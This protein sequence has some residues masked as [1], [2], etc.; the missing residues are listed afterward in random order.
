V[1][2]TVGDFETKAPPA[3]PSGADGSVNWQ[4][5]LLVAE[6]FRIIRFVG[7]GGMGKVY[8]AQDETLGRS[9]ALK[10][11]PQEIIF[12]GDARDDLR[13][14]ANRLLDLAH[15]NIVRIHTYY[16]GPTWP[17]FAMEYLQ[18]PTL[19][20][21][22]RMRKQYGRTFGAGEVLAVARQVARGLS[23]AHAKGIIHRDLKPGNLMIAEPPG[24]R[25]ADADVIKI[26]DFGVSRV[27]A[28]STMRQTGKR[29][30]TLPYMSP[31]QFRGEP[32]TVQSDVYSFACTLYE[33]LSGK[34]PFY[35]GDIG[36]QIMNVSPKPLAGVAKPVRDALVRGLS[37]DPRQRFQSVSE[38]MNALEG[39]GKV[40]KPEGTRRTLS[41]SEKTAVALLAALLLLVFIFIGEQLVEKARDVS[42][43]ADTS[44]GQQ[45]YRN[46]PGAGRSEPG[47]VQVG[48][49][50]TGSRR[51][52]R[53]EFSS[54]L[55]DQ[56]QRQ[57][58]PLVG[59]D[60]A[61]PS[62]GSSDNI[63]LQV[64]VPESSRSSYQRS[65]LDGLL[66]EYYQKDPPGAALSS[67]HAP[68]GATMNVARV[69]G[70]SVQPG[71]SGAA[72]SS[73]LFQ[74]GNLREGA[75]T[76]KAYVEGVG[77]SPEPL[78]EDD[79]ISFRVD[80]TP[81]IFEV[82]PLHPGVF[83]ESLPTYRSTFDEV[84][85]LQLVSTNG[86]DDIAEAFSQIVFKQQA[87]PYE[88]IDSPRSWRIELPPGW[89][90][91]KVFAK[92]A[93]ANRSA[94]REV[95]F[96]RLRLGVESFEL[97]SPEGVSGNLATVK[98]VL[99]VEGDQ[100]PSL[101][102]FVNDRLVQPEPGGTRPLR[103][104]PEEDA[105]ILKGPD[106]LPF[107]GILRLPDL[108]N[109]I[110]V[111]YAWKENPPQPFA[112]PMRIVDVKVRA[113][114]VSLSPIQGRTSQ[115]RAKI[116]GRVEPYFE[117][118]EVALQRPGQGVLKLDLAKTSGGLPMATFA[119]EID[120]IPNENTFRVQCFYDGHLLEPSPPDVSIYYDKERPSL[121]EPLR[122]EVMGE[123]LYVTIR[124]A[125]EL[126]QLR[127][128][129][130]AV[131]EFSG[132]GHRAE[133]RIV[134]PD[135]LS[136]VYK[137]VTMLPSPPS[138]PIT[139]RIE[140]TDLAGNVEYK[141]QPFSLALFSGG[142]LASTAFSERS[143]GR[144]VDTA[145]SRI[146][147]KESGPAARV[148][149]SQ[150]VTLITSRFL[151]EMEMEFV[152]VGQD[153]L[154]MGRAE[155]PERAWFRFLREKSYGETRQGSTNY[156]MTLGDFSPSLLREFV[157]WF[158]E[159]SSDGYAY[160]I[161]TQEQWMAAFCAAGDPVEARDKIKE[162][163]FGTRKDQQRFEP[164]PEVRYGVN[165]VYP[166]GSRKEN[167]TPAGLL[168]ME[169]NVQEVVLDGDAFKVI[170]GSNQENE[171]EILQRTL[172][173]RPFGE[174]ERGPQGR[175]TGFR[176]CR[177]PAIS[178]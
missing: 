145:G 117:G 53:L 127:I 115:V 106:A 76:L 105:G 109:T 88:K 126:R 30:G 36:Y 89:S 50:E 167:R 107:A 149:G 143:S 174:L 35:T 168:D 84:V 114:R 144:A 98:G 171:Q 132:L 141:D 83:V 175:M 135:S 82:E 64:F 140:M 147:D 154:E 42:R 21:L 133:W 121:R 79:P 108:T 99:R 173:A 75:Y 73:R 12:D 29:S 20:K 65:L 71:L 151:E 9:I 49:V 18:G 74:L 162:W 33:L 122:F 102:Y 77:P 34:P 87:L 58:P 119:R 63:S 170:G 120:L 136:L 68:E 45:G 61:S 43:G 139:F 31:E 116:E 130:V 69:R 129:E 166:I 153:R 54:F 10:R 125:E 112:R 67:S 52:E 103:G 40:A 86:I 23:Y 27:V 38:L 142:S 2:V 15:E 55:R 148:T 158:E 172:E 137:Y 160:F 164:H 123:L 4:E 104:E 90:T 19:K 62:P 161:P 14:E 6:R 81:P 152:P 44:G 78:M 39:K 146:E 159:K 131:T 128:Q 59:R 41:L 46:P 51:E 80:L 48:R 25:I 47:T 96:R 178:R 57:I 118:L 150:G 157:K 177:K 26:T 1:D 16:D 100:S 32:C 101:R 156:P 155:V 169:S 17:F 70:T 93:A 66:L 37:K 13:Q 165:K 111:R 28:D 3:A 92:D 176:L 24:E 124:P 5:G 97:A 7:Q 22:L 134:E 8:L 95:S 91:F 72:Q 110:E 60:F 94:A 113:P 56:L 85:D 163:F 11:I 138:R